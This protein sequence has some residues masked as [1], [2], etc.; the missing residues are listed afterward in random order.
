MPVRN[1]IHQETP[2]TGSRAGD[3]VL[4][5][6]FLYG[7]RLYAYY[8]KKQFIRVADN[9]LVDIAHDVVVEFVDVDIIVVGIVENSIE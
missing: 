7:G 3:A 2:P 9:E 8:G 5:D 4:G 1:I 6:F